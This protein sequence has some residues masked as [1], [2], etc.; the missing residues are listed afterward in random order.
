MSTIFYRW[1][2]L[3]TLAKDSTLSEE[4]KRS[5]LYPDVSCHGRGE[6]T[7]KNGEFL[8]GLLRNVSIDPKV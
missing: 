1:Q 2:A 6:V 3:D 8:Y 4:E 5:M 7:W